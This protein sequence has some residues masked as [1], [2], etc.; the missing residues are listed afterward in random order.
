MKTK[1]IVFL[2]ISI[3]SLLFAF[4]FLIMSFR[5]ETYDANYPLIVVLGLI[6]ITNRYLY[7]FLKELLK[8]IEN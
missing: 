2:F 1:P 3:I 4:L 5:F 6:A 7:A 8:K